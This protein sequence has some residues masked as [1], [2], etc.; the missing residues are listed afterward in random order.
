MAITKNDNITRIFFTGFIRLHLLYHAG[1]EPIFGLEMIRE[2]ARHGYQ[3][4]PGTLYPILHGLERDGFLVSGREVA[5]G[6]VRKVYSLTETGRF[7]L[8]D[9]LIKVHELMDEISSPSGK[10]D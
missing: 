1:Q 9:A 3:L 10:E 7:A 6:K 4:S 2:L 8:K 5:A